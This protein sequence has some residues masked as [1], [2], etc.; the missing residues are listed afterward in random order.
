MSIKAFVL[1]RGVRPL[2]F[3]RYPGNN[4]TQLK[5]EEKFNLNEK[6]IIVLPSINLY[7]MLVSE[8][9][10]SACKQYCGKNWR[11]VAQCIAAQT[12]IEPF[13]I[14]IFGDNDKPI[15][16]CG[17]NEKI[18]IHNSV[19]RVRK[20]SLSIPSVKIRPMIL[21][22]WGLKFNIEIEESKDLS[23]ETMRNLFNHSGNIGIGTFRPF[24][25]RFVVDLFEHIK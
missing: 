15:K 19:A 2:M 20:G 4:T 3:D 8:N 17:F 14:P 23:F 12:L 9:G 25:G 10:K 13:E 22:P 18:K 5:P 7:S 6:Y 24:F 21:P 1:L 16:F 11:M